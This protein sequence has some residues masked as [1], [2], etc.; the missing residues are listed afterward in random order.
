MHSI[1]DKDKGDYL[2]TGLNSPSKKEAINDGIEFV[3]SDGGTSA[4]SLVRRFSYVNKEHYLNGHNLIVEEHLERLPD[5]FEDDNSENIGTQRSP[6]G[7][8][9]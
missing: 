6:F 1:F 8:G 2:Y 4:P 5:E 7:I 3:L 9:S